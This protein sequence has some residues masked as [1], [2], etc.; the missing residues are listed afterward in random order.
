MPK[1]AEE[2]EVV[3]DRKEIWGHLR[4]YIQRP[5]HW[6]TLRLEPS[7]WEV[8][9]NTPP[10]MECGQ[11]GWCINLFAIYLMFG[12]RLGSECDTWVGI[13]MTWGFRRHRMSVDLGRGRQRANC[14]RVSLMFANSKQV[15]LCRFWLH[16]IFLMKEEYTQTNLPSFVGTPHDALS[17][18]YLSIPSTALFKL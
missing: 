11:E 15:L 6:H 12:W 9:E 14:S 18:N 17:G 7:F 1:L 16:A 10:R 4:V 13:N 5:A 8:A 2:V 3:Y